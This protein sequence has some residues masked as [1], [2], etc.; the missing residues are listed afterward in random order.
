MAFAATSALTHDACRDSFPIISITAPPKPPAPWQK[1]IV[2]FICPNEERMARNL[3]ND[4]FRLGLSLRMI[5]TDS[6]EFNDEKIAELHASGEIGDTT[7]LVV[8]G[9][10]QN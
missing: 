4:C 3:A 5:H 10:G 6:D 9:H 1:R 8:V 7:Q 2:A